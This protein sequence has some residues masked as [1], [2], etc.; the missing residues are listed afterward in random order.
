MSQSKKIE[1]RM[2]WWLSDRRPFY[3]GDEYKIELSDVDFKHG[4]AKIVITNLKTGLV[5]KDSEEEEA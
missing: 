3:I 4:T 5:E 2:F 1:T